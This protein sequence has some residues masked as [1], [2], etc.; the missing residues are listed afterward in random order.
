MEVVT[1]LL[2]MQKTKKTDRKN[3]KF[4]MLGMAKVSLKQ[5]PLRHNVLLSEN[6]RAKYTGTSYQNHLC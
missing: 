4:F 6:Y 3:N 5:A 2:R 1:L